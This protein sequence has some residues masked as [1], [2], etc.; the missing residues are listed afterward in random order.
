M[1]IKG[2]ILSM[3]RKFAGHSGR[4]SDHQVQGAPDALVANDL[5]RHPSDRRATTQ[6]EGDEPYFP[7]EHAHGHDTTRQDTSRPTFNP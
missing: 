5:L 7:A 3:R 2:N 6:D 4:L 1:D